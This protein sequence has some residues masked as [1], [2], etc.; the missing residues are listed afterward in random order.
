MK[1]TWSGLKVGNREPVKSFCRMKL[2]GNCEP[3]KRH[4]RMKL[5]WSGLKVGNHEPVK[6]H[7]M[8]RSKGWKP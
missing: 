7:H 4:H 5:I 8:V 3:V 6:R 1:L 2:I